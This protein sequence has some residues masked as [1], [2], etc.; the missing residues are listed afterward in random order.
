MFTFKKV[1]TG[2]LALMLALPLGVSGLANQSVKADSAKVDTVNVTLHKYVFSDK[3]PSTTVQNTDSTNDEDFTKLGGKTLDGVTFTA[4]DVT[5]EYQKAYKNSQDAQE[6]SETVA[7]KD[8]DLQKTATK[9]AEATTANGGLANFKDLA[10]RDSDGN[11]KAYL[12]VETNSP[13]NVTQKSASFV[14]AMPIYKGDGSSKEIQTN[15]NVWPKSVKMEDSKHMTASHNDFT[16]GESI[17]YVINT[18]IP[19][20][21]AQKTTYTIT[22][23]PDKGLVMD[24]DSIA[25]EGLNKSDY[26]VTKN[27]DNGFTIEI[28]ANKLASFA[29][30]TLKTTVNGHLSINDLTL[31]DT[32]IYNSAQAKVD[33]EFHTQVKSE[34]VYTGGK[35]FVKVDSANSDKK[36]SGAHF[37]LVI[38]DSN[39]NIVS[40][41]HGDEKSG[42]TFDSKNENVAE[43]TS[44]D[45][46]AF[47]F[48]GLKYSTELASGQSYAVVETKAPEGYELPTG[49]KAIT[50]FK[51]AKDSYKTT[52]QIQTITNVKGGGFLPH[53][54][55]MGIVA[56]IACGLVV[57]GLALAVMFARK[58]RQDNI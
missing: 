58:N 52:S 28:A 51:V 25:I 45:N 17:P 15:V 31:I 26:T 48:A 5:S 55:G 23:T 21:I 9:V 27:S 34:E 13:A 1:K 44:D 54:G 35:K 4:Y 56:F 36:L 37:Q 2:L 41:A 33:N 19:W 43:K 18:V 12:F 24:T 7:K 42:Y 47:E 57:M 46:G 20:N 49:T 53:T 10:L 22:D 39:N 16:A 3:L 29:G 38:V 30:Q 11:Y 14:L 8:T 50:T 40:Y 6:A 32:N